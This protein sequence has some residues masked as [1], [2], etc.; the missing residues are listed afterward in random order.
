MNI[1]RNT[2]NIKRTFRT[3]KN[4]VM[5]IGRHI[6]KSKRNTRKYKQ[7]MLETKIPLKGTSRISKK[8][9]DNMQMGN[10]DNYN[11]LRNTK[12]K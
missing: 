5:I 4:P 7:H 1:K 12:V 3:A 11:I 6:R 9:T 10:K 8:N 2:R